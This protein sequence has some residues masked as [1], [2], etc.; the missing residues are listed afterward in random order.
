MNRTCPECDMP[1]TDVNEGFAMLHFGS[2]S[3]ICANPECP[4]SPFY[5]DD[6]LELGVVEKCLEGKVKMEFRIAFKNP[7][8]TDPQQTQRCT[9]EAKSEAEVRDIYSD[10]IIEYVLPMEPE[11]TQTSPYISGGEVIYPSDGASER[12]IPY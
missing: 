3:W 12:E 8:G 10:Y 9:V 6:A 5:R 7:H 2:P 11:G 4:R 1:M